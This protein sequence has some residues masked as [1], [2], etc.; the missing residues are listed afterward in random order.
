MVTEILL[1]L[2][3]LVLG[4]VITIY[5]SLPRVSVA[6]E[7]PFTVIHS[8][9]GEFVALRVL[10]SNKAR[11]WTL[12]SP[13]IRCRGTITVYNKDGHNF[14][15][16]VL[17]GRWANTPQP[18][19]DRIL[20]PDG[21]ELHKLDIAWYNREARRD[22]YPGEGENEPF[23]IAARFGDDC[24]I[25]NNEAYIEGNNPLQL[26]AEVYFVK[27]IIN[28]SGRDFPF[29]FRLHNDGQLDSFRLEDASKKE[30]K[31]MLS[32]A[33]AGRWKT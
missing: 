26:K 7:P 30:K 11:W 4:A 33:N 10:V 27:V 16:R 22:I 13:A 25:W 3:S 9:R 8:L 17:I 18:E 31:L 23:D 28:V 5:V 6:I 32:T 1:T 15:G 19:P 2:V 24:Y 14:F 21:T 12:R 20:M 29:F